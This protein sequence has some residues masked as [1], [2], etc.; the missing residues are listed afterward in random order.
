MQSEH[1]GLVTHVEILTQWG[2][3]VHPDFFALNLLAFSFAI[4]RSSSYRVMCNNAQD[5]VL[6][7]SYK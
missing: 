6:P 3:S 4:G 5:L 7:F 2:L 1:S